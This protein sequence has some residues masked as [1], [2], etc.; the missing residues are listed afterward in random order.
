MNIDIS[1]SNKNTLKFM[2]ILSK[3][4]KYTLKLHY[5]KVLKSN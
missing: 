5:K 4:V 1:E 3:S 2:E